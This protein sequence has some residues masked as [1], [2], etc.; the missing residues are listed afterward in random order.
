MP[1]SMAALHS[2]LN[3]CLFSRSFTARDD[4]LQREEDKRFAGERRQV[5]ETGLTFLYLLL[6]YYVQQK[7]LGEREGERETKRKSKDRDKSVAI[8]YDFK[9]IKEL[10]VR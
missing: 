6:I 5:K 1:V 7:K 2:F 9:L 3:L 8:C 10:V 4:K